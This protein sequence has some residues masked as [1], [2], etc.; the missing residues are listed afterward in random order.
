M[1]RATGLHEPPGQL[2]FHETV[3]AYPLPRAQA[4]PASMF[5]KET[6]VLGT[7]KLQIKSYLKGSRTKFSLPTKMVGTPFQ[8]SVWKALKTIPYGSTISY[9]ELAK[10]IGDKKAVRAVAAA[11]GANAIAL[12]IPCHRVIGS[13]NKLVGYAGGLPVK[14]RLLKLEIP[15]KEDIDEF[16]TSNLRTCKASLT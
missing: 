6:P 2:P 1:S 14:K 7:A 3:P 13:N 4:G 11:N 15:T 10:L 9:L 8:L 16:F 12:M 5:E